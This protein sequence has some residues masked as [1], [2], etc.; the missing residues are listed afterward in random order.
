MAQRVKDLALSTVWLGSPL[1]QGFDPWPG[2]SHIPWTWPKKAKNKQTK[3]LVEDK[4]KNNND[5][6][7]SSCMIYKSSSSLDLLIQRVCASGFRQ[8]Q[9]RVSF[10]HW[11]ASA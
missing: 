4:Y 7:G 5:H 2:N 1:W 8:V 9:R 6:L 10:F 11:V 3:K